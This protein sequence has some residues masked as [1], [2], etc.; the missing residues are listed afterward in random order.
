[1]KK[2]T[3]LNDFMKY[4][5]FI[6]IPEN[7]NMT[8][9][10]LMLTCQVSSKSEEGI[11]LDFEFQQCDLTL[12]YKKNHYYGSLL[13]FKRFTRIHDRDKILKG[14]EINFYRNFQDYAKERKLDISTSTQT[15]NSVRVVLCNG[16][17]LTF[18]Y[19]KIHDDFLIWEITNR[20]G[21]KRLINLVTSQTSVLTMESMNFSLIQYLKYSGFFNLPGNETIS[22]NDLLMKCCLNESHSGISGTILGFRFKNWLLEIFYDDHKELIGENVKFLGYHNYR[23]KDEIIQAAEIHFWE[24]FKDYSEQNGLQIIE[25]CTSEDT[26]IAFLHTGSNLHFDYK[27]EYG[28]YLVSVIEGDGTRFREA[29]RRIYHD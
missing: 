20:F 15:K 21:N 8:L 3:K 26:L 25:T 22:F 19:S 6:E 11:R 23:S 9:N 24:N 4:G 5:G 10:E 7:Q 13:D 16:L 29:Y 14:S 18:H 1:M 2:F 12:I 28:D 17:R 27:E